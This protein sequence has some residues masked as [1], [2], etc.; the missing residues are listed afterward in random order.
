MATKAAMQRAVRLVAKTYYGDEGLWLC[1]AF[2]AINRKLFGG[3]LPQ[4]LITIEMT[5]WSRCLGWS[6]FHEG[7]PPHIIV[8]P[9]LFGIGETNVKPPWGLH[10]EWM[11]K[12]LVFDVLL[13]EC[14]HIAIRYRLG[15]YDGPTSHNNEQWV[16][17]VN[18]ICPLIGLKDVNAGR[19][20]PKRVKV[21]GKS[22]TMVKKVD[23]GNV[24]FKAIAQFPYGLRLHN[25]KAKRYYKS[26]RLPLRIR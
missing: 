5:K 6:Q 23:E 17:E 11:G 2:D 25:K 13:H 21:R 12:R 8:H 15:G 7:R 18:R 16:A 9:T 26:G 14:I 1:Q 24:P 19:Q 10:Q 22:E 20:V 4:P 3:T